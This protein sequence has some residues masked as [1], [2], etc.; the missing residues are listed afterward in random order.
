MYRREVW[1]T[2]ERILEIEMALKSDEEVEHLFE[3]MRHD[4]S[5]KSSEKHREKK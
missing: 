5:K 2:R 1:L 3:E 4:Y